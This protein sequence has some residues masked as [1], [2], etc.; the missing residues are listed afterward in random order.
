MFEPEELMA[1]IVDLEE[2][3]K[4]SEM[5]PPAAEQ[6]IACLEGEI[7][8][9]DE[10][11]AACRVAVENCEVFRA[12]IVELEDDLKCAHSMLAEVSKA[13]MALRAELSAIKAQEP[14]AE[15]KHG[16]LDSSG[17]PEF[18][19]VKTIGDFDLE[20]LPN[21]MKLY[22]APVSEAKAQGVVQWPEADEIMQMAFEEGQPADDASGYCFELEEFDLFIER[23]MSEVAR[24]NAAPAQHPKCKTCDDNGMIG[25]PSFYAPDDGGEPCPDCCSPVQQVSVPDERIIPT[26]AE[27]IQWAWEEE[28]EETRFQEGYNA[29]KRWVKMQIEAGIA[30][31]AAPAS[32][33]GLV[34]ALALCVKSLDQ[35]LPY[36]GKVPA[37]IGLINNALMAARPA[38]AAHRAKGVV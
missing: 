35:L 2:Q 17:W 28:P 4:V 36:L 11:L 15:V 27:L 21:G 18:V 23:L 37:D 1:R 3:L 14:V 9:R 13:G 8:K 32:D 19:R 33:A 26:S 7:A 38:L 22:A 20:N 25:G 10:E 31:P 16:P 29:A 30:A 6:L 34:E 5:A 12:R 24:L